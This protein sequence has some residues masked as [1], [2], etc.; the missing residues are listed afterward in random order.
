M[1]TVYRFATAE[2]V[3]EIYGIETECFATP[4]SET[5]IAEMLAES[6]SLALIATDGVAAGYVSAYIG[7]DV[8]YINNIAVRP[9][10]RRNGIAKQLLRRLLKQ[11]AVQ[12]V[13]EATLEV[14]ASNIAAQSLYASQGFIAMGVRKRYYSC[15]EEDAII[16]N[17]TGVNV[18]AD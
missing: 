8:L 9:E 6:S 14:R 2:D 15:P 13:T 11:A 1:D 18:Y 5:S 4:W 10:F 12:G 17:L 7:G 16:M 3:K